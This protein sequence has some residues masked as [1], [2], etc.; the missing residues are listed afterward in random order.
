MCA[1]CKKKVFHRGRR[2]GGEDSC[3]TFRQY[4]VRDFLFMRQDKLLNIPAIRRMPTY[5]HKL[6]KMQAEG[7]VSVSSTELAEYM[8]IELIVVRKDI[9]LTGISGQRRVGYDIN[10]LIRYIKNY[11]G[12]EDTI[13]AVLIGA[14]SLGTALLGYNDFELYGFHI[15]QVFDSSPGKIGQNI[16]GRTVE[17]IEK[18]SECFA[19]RPPEIA[20][21]CVSNT[22]AQ[23]I[24]DKLVSLEVKYI[25]NFANVSL[26]VPPDVVVQ[27]EV[28]AG[29]LA[30][31]SVR[32]KMNNEKIADKE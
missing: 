26:Q 21:L 4:C 31:L 28:I 29:G 2:S 23:S 3:R 6:L 13:P 9:S 22:A 30:M 12:W 19:V 17:D 5:L 10:E 25:W 11:L 7:R 20:V 15:E 32:R 16:Y 24:A 18:M 14:G 8:K 1:A 27:R